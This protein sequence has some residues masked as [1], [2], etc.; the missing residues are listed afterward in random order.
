[1]PLH[2]NKMSVKTAFMSRWTTEYCTT[3][4][5]TA[6][7]AATRQHM[8]IPFEWRWQTNMD[9]LSAIEDKIR[10]CK[11]SVTDLFLYF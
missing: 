2:L 9:V 4:Y 7:Q 8:D 6:A 11:I 3:Q 1:M 5:F 10:N